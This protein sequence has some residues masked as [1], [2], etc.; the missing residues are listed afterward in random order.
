M[1]NDMEFKFGDQ[2]IWRYWHSIHPDHP[3][4]RRKAGKFLKYMDMNQTL[5]SGGLALVHLD[6]NKFPS[7][8]KLKDLSRPGGPNVKS[9]RQRGA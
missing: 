4:I 2:I 9:E 7:R 3:F 1:V 5:C 8:I 6:G